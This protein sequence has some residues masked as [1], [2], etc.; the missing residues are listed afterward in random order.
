MAFINSLVPLLP[1]VSY[2]TLLISYDDTTEPSLLPF[3]IEWTISIPLLLINLGKLLHFS[4]LHY[5][6]T[7]TIPV[8][9]TLVGYAS[10]HSKSPE[11]IF[12]L[13]GVSGALYVTTMTYLYTLYRRRARE[14]LQETNFPH[15]LEQNKLIVFK[16]LFKIIAVSWNGYPLTFIL[17][18]TENISIEAAIVTFACLD[19]VAK[20]LYILTLLCYKLTLYRQSGL[21]VSAFRRIVKVHPIPEEAKKVPTTLPSETPTLTDD[22]YILP[23]IKPSSQIVLLEPDE[24]PDF[25]NITPLPTMANESVAAV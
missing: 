7:C 11:T 22:V 1:I 21:L 16:T 8:I 13:F 23:K 2:T 9:M 4:V 3:F 18:K 15:V 25:V 5:A 20:G 6:V 19:F 12:A 24:Y 17:W 14:K 10:A